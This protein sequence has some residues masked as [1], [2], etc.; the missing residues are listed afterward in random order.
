MVFLSFSKFV[1]LGLGDLLYLGIPVAFISEC[2]MV[3]CDFAT[4]VSIIHL[5]HKF[6]CDVEG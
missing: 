6:E 3:L 5:D 1:G 2:F 4:L